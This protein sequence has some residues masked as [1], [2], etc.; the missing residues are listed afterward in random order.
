[1]KKS[2]IYLL[3]ALIGIVILS[4]IIFNPF[5]KKESYDNIKNNPELEKLVVEY[6]SGTISKNSDII[7]RFTNNVINNLK[8]N[9]DINNVI[10]LSPN[11]KGS[12]TW[13]DKYTIEFTPAK[14][15]TSGAKYEITY[16]IDELTDKAKELPEFNSQINIVKQNFE[17]KILEQVTIDKKQLKYQ[18][19]IGQ[20]LMADV[21]NIDKIKSIL[22]ATQNQ[23]NLKIKFDPSNDNKLF[24]FNIDSIKRYNKSSEVKLKI[25]GKNLDIDKE[26]TKII[27]IPAINDFSVLKIETFTYPE[28]YI[29]IQFTDPLL[30]NQ[31]LRG[32]VKIVDSQSDPKYEIDN[33]TLKIY[34]ATK[35][36]GNAIIKIFSGVKNILG[37]DFNKT[38]QFP[39]TFE[40][41]KPNVRFVNDGVILPSSEKG[42]ILPFEAVN[43]KAIDVRITKIYNNNILQ[44]LQVNDL[45]GYNQ[46]NRV[47]KVI[48]KKTIRLDK[49]N[50]IDFSKWN[51]FVLNLSDLINVDKGSIYR[52][53]INFTKNYSTFAC[54]DSKS[55]NK[56]KE[57][58]NWSYF[59]DYY[60]GEYDEYG[61]YNDDY[62]D[63]RDNP[64]YNAY[65]GADRKISQNIL[66]TDLGVIVKKGNNNSY[67][68][69]VNN[70]L[71][72]DPIKNVN[73]E[74]Y[75]YQQQIIKKEITDNNGMVSVKNLKDVSFIIVNHDK[76]YN[77][78]KI[79]SGNSLS[80]SRFDVSGVNLKQGLKGYIYGERGVWR[81][82][83]S[84]FI[85]FMLQENE[86]NIIAEGTPI[87]AKLYNTDY[88]LI[89]KI[90][91][92]KNNTNIYVFKFKTS[93]DAQT[94]VWSI[95]IDVGGNIFYKDLKIETIKPNRLKINLSFDKKVADKETPLNSN[96]HVEWLHGAIGKNLKSLIEA[97]FAK[98]PLNFK[99]YT[100]Y[101]F[102]DQTKKFY[103]ETATIFDGKTDENGN[104][105]FKTFFDVD[106]QAPGKLKAIINTKVFEPGG[107][108][109]INQTTIPF[110][111]YNSYVGIKI[112]GY[113]NNNMYLTDT[114]NFAELIVVDKNGKLIT[115]E[116]PLEIKMYKLEWRWWW[117]DYDDYLANYIG[118]S[119]VKPI[120]SKLLFTENGKASWKFRI[121]YPDWGRYLIR[122]YD[123]KSK[124]STSK[125]VYLDWPEFYSREN[126][127]HASGATMIS[128]TAD[129]EKYKV[130]ET[131]NLT[132]PT[133][134]KG[135]ALITIENGA[136]VLSSN[137]I[138]ITE[139]ETHYSFTVTK[140][141]TPNIYVGLTLL[142]PHSQTVND[143]PIRLY[144]ILPLSIEDEDTHLYPVI[145][146]PD[147][148]ESEKEVKIEISEKND[149][150]MYFTLAVV[151][152]GLL[153]ITNFKT[154]EPWYVFYAKEAL[155][156]VTWDIYDYVIG[157]FSGKIEQ[158]L[159][160]GGGDEG[161]SSSG[162]KANR[163]KPV[164]KYF[165]PLYVKGGRKKTIKFKMP[166][167]IGAVKTMVVA[168]YKKSY[169]SAEKI[170]KVTKPLMILGTLPR[171]LSPNETVSLPV[172]VFA[173]EKNIKTVKLSIQTN[174]LVYIADKKTKTINFDKPDEKTEFFTLKTK[175]KTGI[176]KVHII[177]SSG[178]KKTTYDIELNVK[179]PN[180][181]TTD[182]I[183]N[184]IESKSQWKTPFTPIG[185]KGTNKITL[186]VSS[187]PPLNLEKRL[188]YLISY[189]YGCVEQT[190]SSAFPQLYL[191]KLMELNQ[192]QKDKIETNVK[193]AISRLIAF[194]IS[195]G[196]LGYWPNSQN[197]SEWGTN[198]AG[199]FLI[200][201][202]NK[203]YT[204]SKNFMNKWKKY[205]NLKAKKWINDGP[206]S[207]II[208]AYRLYT[209][210]LNNTPNISAMNRLKQTKHLSATAKW[211]LAAA[212]AIIGK[213]RVANNLV[214]NLSANTNKY[215]GMYYTYG[216][217]TRDKAMILETLT[218]LNKKKQAYT[219]L[220]EISD[221]LSSDDWLS[222]Q[223]IAYSLIAMSG[224]VEKNISSANLNFSYKL[225]NGKTIKINTHKPVYKVN[226]PV[227][228]LTE[229]NL[230]VIN[231][232][233]GIIFTKLALTGIPDIGNETDASN[234]INLNVQYVGIDGSLINPENIEQGTDFA[235]IVSVNNPTNKY[236]NNIALS[237]VFPSGWEI[238]NSRIFDE[239]V[240]NSNYDTPDYSD[241][242]DDRIY[243]F[244][245]L[246]PGTTKL[247]KFF[248]NASYSGHYY[249][250]AVNCELMYNGEINAKI[251]GKWI[252]VIKN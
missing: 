11:V 63:N 165:G 131:V 154:P 33:N 248:L 247:F 123:R 117:E 171:T 5:T 183:S 133:P 245:D 219:I 132:I 62:W 22:S 163:F 76:Q 74:F 114:N 237:Q 15:F 26:E 157:A 97:D 206:S 16:N 20:I 168:K 210:A 242:R 226:I 47:G 182:V 73:V 252:D 100:D 229:Q 134:N 88:K 108:F 49:S 209:L 243:S 151:D 172:S 91:K 67:N 213:T 225:Q 137:W 191:N 4:F 115:K 211:R 104:A 169:G 162:K 42:L 87:I 113:Q 35:I 34:P 249:L 194:Q 8:Q 199:H 203:G 140:D 215:V 197:V 102:E 59:D 31:D 79:N 82:G 21:E 71:T 180:T 3:I 72:T 32:I 106:N 124:N 222:T 208:Q 17:V 158:L 161:N 39:I 119:Y 227:K 7:I 1:M 96:L 78:V 83:D 232:S 143:L 239:Q 37:K 152:E 45:N 139:T 204:V 120:K 196:G 109:S 228:T 103:P 223:T 218:L 156:V 95:K 89:K 148:L 192:E 164:V 19:V 231:N 195:N 202:K 150:D 147:K 181:K 178:N 235:V 60:Y 141:M 92:H 55:N 159:N 77:Y 66:A 44:F 214:M 236:Y 179:N 10:E 56:I 198:Y 93:P 9:Y 99:K 28:Q 216:S 234:N 105:S 57:T 207:Q 101:T 61:N 36:T 166:K 205:Q 6:T 175:T 238:L 65:Y 135:K 173:M 80:L 75:N 189:P 153:D 48:I 142:Q 188:N 244:F 122:V 64:C 18:K 51:R 41:V 85:A 2:K 233:T 155:G 149:K 160:I 126:T 12:A 107:N 46:I 221:K 185:I 30:I 212:Y 110:Y 98:I 184:I 121:N 224:Y 250:P 170:S 186:E 240:D 38:R 130:G 58:T 246:N 145:D 50:I 90:I 27:K 217:I 54:E 136:K 23:D 81:P 86:K 24:I 177:A 174:N 187:I 200:E 220:K 241:I 13:I 201:A 112:K 94:G 128:F 167:Y 84:L 111:P 43:L 52:I 40:E 116:H 14:P 70:I 129:K 193:N 125:I 25:N 138:D 118:R 69:Y 146:M 251:K 190:T 144:G 68:V 29:K 53:E 127:N 176:A 230:T